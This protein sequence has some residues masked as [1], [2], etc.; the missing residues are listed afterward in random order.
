M[1]L[2]ETK[3]KCF[4]DNIEDWIFSNDKAKM[5]RRLVEA[6]AHFDLLLEKKPPQRMTTREYVNLKRKIG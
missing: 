3:L 2:L 6:E 5:E 4:L 1:D